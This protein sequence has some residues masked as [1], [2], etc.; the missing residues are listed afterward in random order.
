[1]KPSHTTL[2]LAFSGKFR[3]PMVHYI[4]RDKAFSLFINIKA[5]GLNFE[6]IVVRVSINEN[7]LNGTE[8]S[9]CYQLSTY[10]VSGNLYTCNFKYV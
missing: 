3:G 1:M 2:F 4:W 8:K 9:I 7:C 6:V 10:T 5:L